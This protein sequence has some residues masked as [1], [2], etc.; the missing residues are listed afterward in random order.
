MRININKTK[1]LEIVGDDLE[2]DENKEYYILIK[3]QPT[4]EEREPSGER[5]QKVAV[6]NGLAYHVSKADAQ[7][8]IAHRNG[9]QDIVN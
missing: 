8:L 6:D 7:Y 2:N 1:G 4:K 5:T 3:V 9:P